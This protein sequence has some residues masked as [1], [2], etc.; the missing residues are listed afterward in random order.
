M[1]LVI[2]FSIKLTQFRFII[3]TTASNPQNGQ[4]FIDRMLDRSSSKSNLDDVHA[5]VTSDRPITF[6]DFCAV[7]KD[8]EREDPSWMEPDR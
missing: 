6:E 5:R 2:R 7:M 1:C 3:L 8:I 4:Y